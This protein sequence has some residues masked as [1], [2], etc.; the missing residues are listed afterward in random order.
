VD[1]DLT[2]FHSQVPV[3]EAAS[4]RSKPI[5]HVAGA[6]AS[7]VGTSLRWG[8]NQVPR[9]NWK[10]VRTVL[11]LSRPSAKNH[12][13]SSPEI[14]KTRQR[15]A[16]LMW[17]RMTRMI[18]QD[19][20]HIE[21]YRDECVYQKSMWVN[22]PGGIS[23]QTTYYGHLPG[24]WLVLSIIGLV[25]VSSNKSQLQAFPVFPVAW[26]EWSSNPYAAMLAL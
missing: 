25:V 8:E 21:A 9:I 18:F 22:G 10:L 23:L 12:E 26:L 5:Q 16:S 24:H 3:E 2:W 6:H 20:V 19:L 4:D 15:D 7:L 1:I 11:T 17:S 14:I 13:K